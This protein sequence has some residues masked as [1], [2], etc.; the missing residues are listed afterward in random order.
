MASLS[1]NLPPPAEWTFRDSGVLPEGVARGHEGFE[2]DERD[3]SAVVAE[4]E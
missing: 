2:V 4:T 3:G 1:K